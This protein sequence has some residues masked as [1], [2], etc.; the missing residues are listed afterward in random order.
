M[1]Y[2][3]D[4]GATGDR[5][6][7][8]LISSLW[9]GAERW[10]QCRELVGE[11]GIIIIYTADILPTVYQAAAFYKPVFIF[12][13]SDLYWRRK[14]LRRIY[15]MSLDGCIPPNKTP[16]STV[17]AFGAMTDTWNVSIYVHIMDKILQHLNFEIH[18]RK[19]G[20]GCLFMK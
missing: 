19:C 8:S 17:V 13:T 14:Y 5:C 7:S 9:L 12:L 11:K 18:H 15:N 6:T 16:Q 2:S 20:L 10:S 4:N 3:L 1:I